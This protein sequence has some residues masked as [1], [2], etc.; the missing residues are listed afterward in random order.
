MLFFNIPYQVPVFVYF[1]VFFSK[2]VKFNGLYTLL[3][4][5]LT[6]SDR[7]PTYLDTCLELFFWKYGE[8]NALR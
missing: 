8:K 5:N 2:Y 6:N 3:L 7:T 1:T 4:E